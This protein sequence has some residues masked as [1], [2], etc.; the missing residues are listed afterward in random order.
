[1]AL[2]QAGDWA[3]ARQELQRALTLRPTFEGAAEAKKALE[4][5]GV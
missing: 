4:M 5:I 2:V 1:M 3:K